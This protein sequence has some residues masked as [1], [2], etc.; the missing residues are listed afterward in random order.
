[1]D[2]EF[3]TEEQRAKNGESIVS[4]INNVGKTG[5]PHAKKKW[6]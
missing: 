5:K 4:S 6:N 3:M 1:M 2:D